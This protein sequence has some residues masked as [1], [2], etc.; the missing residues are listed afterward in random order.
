MYNIFKALPK[1]LIMYNAN[2]KPIL[3]LFAQ[4]TRFLAYFVCRFT[5]VFQFSIS[6]VIINT[7]RTTEFPEENMA[8]ATCPTEEV[9][10]HTL[11]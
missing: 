2:R 6:C 1:Q 3:P 8:V 9:S 10:L 7:Q 4:L 5:S 11:L